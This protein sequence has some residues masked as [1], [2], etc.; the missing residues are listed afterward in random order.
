MKKW[1]STFR[2]CLL[3]AWGGINPFW[4]SHGSQGTLYTKMKYYAVKISAV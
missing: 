1:V 3:E 2:L 4:G